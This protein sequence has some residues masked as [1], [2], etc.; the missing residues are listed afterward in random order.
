MAKGPEYHIWKIQDAC[1]VRA[2]L[3]ALSSP[4]SSHTHPCYDS[5]DERGRLGVCSRT[6]TFWFLSRTDKKGAS[7]VGLVSIL[8]NFFQALIRVGMLFSLQGAA[9]SRGFPMHQSS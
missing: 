9:A 5:T 8:L 2:C 4:P 3:T 6:R 7:A 1:H